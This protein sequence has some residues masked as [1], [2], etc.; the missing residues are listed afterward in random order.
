MRRT[1]EAVEPLAGR[2]AELIRLSR[3]IQTDDTPVKLRDGPKKGVA[4]A[5]FWSYVGDRAHPYVAYDFSANRRGEHPKKWLSTCRGYLQ[6]DAFAG[7]N[8]LTAPGQPLV[9]VGC[10]AHARRKFHD[11]RISHSARAT[12]ILDLIRKLYAVEEQARTTPDEP[13]SRSKSP[14]DP[15]R[16]HVMRN[17]HARTVVDAIFATLRQWRPEEPPKSALGKAIGYALNQEATL[18]RY[19]D[20]GELEIDNNACER[21]LRGIALGRKNWLFAGSERGG[22]TAATL[23]TVIGSAR[24]HEIEPWAYVKD[25]LERMPHAPWSELDSFLPD[26]WLKAHPTATLSLNR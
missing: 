17:E 24:L 7:Y 18:R 5:R 6:S 23:F 19:L 20:N 15:A 21:S 3:I 13:E 22:R 16:R 11:A 1:A 25:V 12:E 2:I 14:P 8:A 9:S 4:E 26:R 10:W